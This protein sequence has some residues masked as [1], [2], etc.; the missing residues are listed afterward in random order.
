MDNIVKQRFMALNALAPCAIKI[1]AN[2]DW[3]ISHVAVE[4]QDGAVLRSVVG[5]GDTPE[6]AIEDHWKQAT[7]LAPHQYLV[8]DAFGVRKRRA[9]RWNGFMWAEVQEKHG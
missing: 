8:I 3:Y 9:F 4:I 6:K 1:D 5:R 2:C 7:E